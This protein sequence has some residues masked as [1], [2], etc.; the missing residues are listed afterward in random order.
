MKNN[1]EAIIQKD[2]ADTLAETST[3]SSLKNTKWQFL[4]FRNDIEKPSPNFI[5]D[6]S[7]LYDKP[8]TLAE[9]TKAIQ[10]SH[11]TTV[12]TNEIHN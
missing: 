11:N 9:L 12:G 3:N 5:S 4:N 6:N 10:R 2:I 7:E 1:T 8:F